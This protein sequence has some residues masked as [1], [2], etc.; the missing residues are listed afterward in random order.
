VGDRADR[1]GLGCGHKMY[2]SRETRYIRYIV[3]GQSFKPLHLPLHG[4]YNPVTFQRSGVSEERRHPKISGDGPTT[5]G[6]ARERLPRKNTKG[7][8]RSGKR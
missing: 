8:K 3:D 6:L 2:I 7:H 5:P 4:R 1:N